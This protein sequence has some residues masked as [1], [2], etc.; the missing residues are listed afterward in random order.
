MIYDKFGVMPRSSLRAIKVLLE[1]DHWLVNHRLHGPA[2][3][4]ITANRE[5]FK[6]S[7]NSLIFSQF[8]LKDIRRL[9][10]ATLL[11]ART[12]IFF[13]SVIYKEYYHVNLPQSHLK[14]MYCT[15]V[16]YG[17]STEQVKP[18]PPTE[19]CAHLQDEA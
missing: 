2:V 6:L 9:W 11:T 1:S 17:F 4:D 13:T 16:E 3:D 7:A 19:A 8:P 14:N 10:L 18:Q 12:F 15:Y 5:T